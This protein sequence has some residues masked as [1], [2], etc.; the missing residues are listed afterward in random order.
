MPMTRAEIAAAVEALEQR[1]A[2]FAVHDAVEGALARTEWDPAGDGQ[3]AQQDPG[4]AEIISAN[5]D[6]EDD[7]AR[8]LRAVELQ[9]QGHAS[10]SP[11]GYQLLA[12]RIIA[13]AL[14]PDP[15]AP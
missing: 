15:P 4:I 2:P 7:V 12:R 1:G 8:C 10:R 14:A 5:V 6:V 11:R 3:A 9:L 13:D